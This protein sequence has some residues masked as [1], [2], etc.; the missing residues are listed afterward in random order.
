[1][2]KQS[3]AFD[4]WDSRSHRDSR[5]AESRGRPSTNLRS[6]SGGTRICLGAFPGPFPFPSP[7]PDLSSPRSRTPFLSESLIPSRNPFFPSFFPTFSRPLFALSR[8]TAK[9]ISMYIGLKRRTRARSQ[10]TVRWTVKRLILPPS[11]IGKRPFSA[12]SR[13]ME[14]ERERKR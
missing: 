12:G 2:T 14:N 4:Q 9:Y 13:K 10:F 6:V 11:Q 8:S 1:M 3:I 7:N 5:E